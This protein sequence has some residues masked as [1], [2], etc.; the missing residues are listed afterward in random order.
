[1]DLNRPIILYMHAGSGNHGC[2][3]IANSTL[4]LIAKK[5]Q[6]AGADTSLPVIVVTNSVDEDRKY[7]L[8]ALEKQGLCSLVEDR[9]MDRELIP[10]VLYYVYRKVTGDRESFFAIQ[11]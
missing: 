11:V 9:H 8:G 5:R 10:H 2:E 6:E 4:K 3:A 7:S 1:M